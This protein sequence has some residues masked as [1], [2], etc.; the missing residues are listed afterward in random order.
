MGGTVGI[1]LGLALTWAITRV[2]GL[3]FVVSPVAVF[4]GAFFSAAVGI[5][6]GLYP[7]NKAASLAPVDALRYE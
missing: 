4:G 5:F 6:F 2:A 7:A 1:L 3:P